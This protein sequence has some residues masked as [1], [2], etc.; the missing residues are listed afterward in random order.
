M[1]INERLESDRDF[2]VSVLSNLLSTRT[3]CALVGYPDHWNVGDTAIWIGTQELLRRLQI[4]VDYTCGAW[5]YNPRA[6]EAAVPN[7]PILLTGGGNFGDVYPD[8][9]TLRNR[10]LSDFPHRRIIQL[11]Q[12]IWFREPANLKDMAGRLASLH[13]FTFLARDRNSLSMARDHFPVNSLLCP[14]LALSLP[15]SGRTVAAEVPIFALWR[16]DVESSQGAKLQLHNG[17]VQDWIVPGP[18]RR[19]L[20][21]VIRLFLAFT[22]RPANGG[23]YKASR[24]RALGWKLASGLWERLARERVWRGC[25]M[26][27]RGQVVITNRLHGHLLCTLMRIPHVVCDTVNG[28]ISAYRDTWPRVDPLLAWAD[29]PEEA[30]T[31][32]RRMLKRLDDQ[33]ETEQI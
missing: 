27:Q 17:I 1:T 18:E 4:K 28:K 22:G 3:A 7:G 30:V 20:T 15:L 16:D 11:P 19:Q 23:P 13:D 31:K 29:S 5:S 14:D 6:L 12:S 32:A 10:V 24:Q 8:E 33:H 21:A 25:R 9:T 26:L 2:I